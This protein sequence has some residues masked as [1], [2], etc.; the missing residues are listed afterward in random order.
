MGKLYVACCNCGFWF[1]SSACGTQ[2]ECSCPKCGAELKY[3]VGMEFIRVQ[4]KGTFK[5][6]QKIRIRRYSN[7]YKQEVSSEEEQKLQG[8]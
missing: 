8:K 3:T 4:M 2:T 5:N 6:Q 7:K 1:G